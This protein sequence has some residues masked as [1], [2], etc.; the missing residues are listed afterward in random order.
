MAERAES[1]RLD[2]YSYDNSINSDSLDLTYD[3][4]KVLNQKNNHIFVDSNRLYPIVNSINE[5]NRGRN[6]TRNRKIP[7]RNKIITSISLFLISLL[8]ILSIYRVVIFSLK[9]SQYNFLFLLLV[10]LS[11]FILLFPLHILISGLFNMLGSTEFFFR[12]NKYYSCTIEQ[13]RSLLGQNRQHTVTIQ[14]PVYKEDFNSVI[15]PTIKSAMLCKK[16]YDR[17][18]EYDVTVNIFV[19]DDGL[20]VIDKKE[21]EKRINYYTRHNIGY[22]ARPQEGRKGKFKKASNMNFCLHFSKIYTKLLNQ[23]THDESIMVAKFLFAKEGN[24]VISHG[25]ITLGDFI[26]LL[27]SDT[28]IPYDCLHNVLDEF[29]EDPKLGFTQHL[30]Y[31]LIVTN[32][33]WERFIAHFTTLIYDLA[34]PISISGG[35]ISPLVGHCAILRVSALK[36]LENKKQTYKIWSESN[37]SEDF[38]LFMELTI[39]GYFGRYITYTSNTNAKHFEKHNFMEGISLEY[40]DELA[41]FKKYAYGTCEILFNPIADWYKKG[42]IGSPIK[43]YCR[44]NIELTSKIGIVSY[45]FTYIAIAISLPTSFINF[46]T[47]GW[48][49]KDIDTNVLPVYVILQIAMLFSVWGTFTNSVFKARVLKKDVINVIWYNFEQTPFYILFFGSLPFHLVTIIIKYFIGYTTITWGSTKKEISYS[50]KLDALLSTFIE[51][52]CMYLFFT[53]TIIV[54][55]FMCSNYIPNEWRIVNVNALTPLVMTTFF[56]IFSPILLNPYIMTNNKLKRMVDL[57][58]EHNLNLFINE[59]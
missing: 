33:Y 31:P 53:F 7:N 16:Y 51:F 3:E 48:V 34:M 13:T 8:F 42:I 1:D 18:T 36:E 45:L 27:D 32:T 22:V 26:L 37:V 14:I 43:E 38:K 2:N 23:F 59:T 50:S 54:I 49:K 28:R 58:D 56:H 52:K 21:A 19:N 11:I 20:Q 29:D 17:M 9:H 40:I 10:L 47:F 24:I 30:T 12:N 39:A 57:D 44:S 5:Y 35:D 55:C 4:T 6:L 15:K 46:F 41:K 25:D